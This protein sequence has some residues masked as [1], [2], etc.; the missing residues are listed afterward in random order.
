MNETI[1]KVILYGLLVAVIVTLA[2]SVLGLFDVKIFD[3]RSTAVSAELKSA[4]APA[5]P[6][7]PFKTIETGT[8]DTGDVSIALTPQPVTN[9]ILE[10]SAAVNTHSVALDGFDLKKNTLLEYGG[11]ENRSASGSCFGWASYEWKISV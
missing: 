6:T 5:V 7:S 8:T 1:E 9:G 10:V 3:G 4:P 2:F 11:G